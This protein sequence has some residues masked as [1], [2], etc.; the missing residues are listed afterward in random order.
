MIK[1]IGHIVRGWAKYFGLVSTSSAE[2]KL[3]DL[4][5]KVCSSCFYS[6]SKKIIEIIN[7]NVIHEAT[8]VCTK[9]KCPC[10]Q[11]T[12]VVDETCPVEKW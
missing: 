3:S 10:M 6:D 2:A 1:K 5:L 11:K 4:R 12:L 9:C 7:G 8:L